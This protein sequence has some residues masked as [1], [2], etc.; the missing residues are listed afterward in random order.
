MVREVYSKLSRS[1]RRIEI[2]RKISIKLA[3]GYWENSDY[4]GVGRFSTLLNVYSDSKG[5]SRCRGQSLN[6]R[7][8]QATAV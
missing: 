3:A 4:N 2:V 5:K 1:S 8:E 7:V 6:G